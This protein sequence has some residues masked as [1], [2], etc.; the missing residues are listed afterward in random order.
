MLLALLILD[1]PTGVA[2]WFSLVPM[3]LQLS[4]A[5]AAGAVVDFLL[6][7]Q[8]E[9]FLRLRVSPPQRPPAAVGGTGRATAG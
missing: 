6:C 1:L 4:G 3:P 7:Y 8:W 9:A 2:G 5:V